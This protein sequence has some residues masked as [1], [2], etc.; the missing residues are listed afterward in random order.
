KSQAQE[1]VQTVAVFKLGAG[2]HTPSLPVAA[3]RSHPPK[4]SNFK[5]SDRRAGGVSKGAAARASSTP[6][7]A[8]SSA[9]PPL[10]APAAKTA[11]TGTN[12]SEWETF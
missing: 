5:G 1:L 11:A 3:V 9:P 2:D 8:A 6:K 4:P 10:A 7:P 12:D